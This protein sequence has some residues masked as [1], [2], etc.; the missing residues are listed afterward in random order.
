[1]VADLKSAGRH[2]PVGL[3]PTTVAT[4]RRPAS[5]SLSGR[6]AFRVVSNSPEL[7]YLFPNSTQ[8]MR[9]RPTAGEPAWVF[10]QSN[11]QA[12]EIIVQYGASGC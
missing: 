10:F 7:P 3:N 6:R 2:R 11:E 9:F 1:M 5:T 12:A 4:T 8:T